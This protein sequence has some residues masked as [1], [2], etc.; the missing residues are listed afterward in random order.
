MPRRPIP[1]SRTSIV[2]ANQPISST[3]EAVAIVAATLRRPL[4]SEVIAFLV[5]SNNCG[6]TIVVVSHDHDDDVVLRVAESMM[7]MAAVSRRWTGVV[8]ASV[9]PRSMIVPGDVD[10]WLELDALTASA[11]VTLKDWLVVG[12]AGVELPRQLLG[13]PERW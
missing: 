11:G 6:H 5:D 7:A 8:L 13:E 9:R 4:E 12:P 3:D 10:R 1:C 2:H